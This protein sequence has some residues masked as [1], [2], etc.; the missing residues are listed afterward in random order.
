MNDL[1]IE[2]KER[3]VW[4]ENTEPRFTGKKDTKMTKVPYDM[5]TKKYTHEGKEVPE[6]EPISLDIQTLTYTLV[7]TRQKMIMS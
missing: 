1:I 3:T 7:S 4:L 6:G 5:R 2:D